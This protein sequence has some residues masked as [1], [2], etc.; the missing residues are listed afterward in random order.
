MYFLNLFI[1]KHLDKKVE[2]LTILYLSNKIN[3][4][5]NEVKLDIIAS[6]N[7]LPGYKS[8]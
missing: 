1:L 5:Q 4:S 8:F 3:L 6:D 7:A 2:N